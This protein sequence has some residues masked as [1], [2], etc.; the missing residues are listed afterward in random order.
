MSNLRTRIVVWI[1]KV[2]LLLW[3][4]F[5]TTQVVGV[6]KGYRDLQMSEQMLDDAVRLSPKLPPDGDSD[7]VE[8]AQSWVDSSTQSLWQTTIALPIFAACAAISYFGR[9]PQD[10]LGPEYASGMGASPVKPAE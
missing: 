6:Y 10:K 7:W 5:T 2:P 3:L 8:R 4:F 9:P 1:C